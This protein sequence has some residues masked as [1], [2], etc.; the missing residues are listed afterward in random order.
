MRLISF[1][2][3]LFS[4]SLSPA[5]FTADEDEKE[6]KKP[7]IYHSLSP[8]LITNVQGNAKYIRCDVQLMT[9]N[10]D[11][12]PEIELHAAA[13]R[14]DLLLLFSEQQGDELKKP[15]G[16]ERLRKAALKAIRARMEALSGE[17]R[18]EDLFFTSYFVK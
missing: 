6:E 14:H 8:S 5:G 18:I 13:I 15:K 10:E 3:F 7:V 1:I 16:K 11:N 4:L 12:I 2:I 17:A 9:R